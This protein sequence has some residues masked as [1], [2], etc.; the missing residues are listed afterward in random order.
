LVAVEAMAFGLPVVTT[1]WRS[2]PEMLPPGY[3]GLV[4]IK[5]PNQI[6]DALLAMMVQPNGEYL[7]E[8]FLNRFTLQRYLTNHAEAIHSVEIAGYTPSLAPRPQTF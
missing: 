6:A 1:C 2:L 4:A 5:S 7:R 3:P 8:N